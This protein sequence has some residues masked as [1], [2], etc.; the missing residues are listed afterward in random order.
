MIISDTD[1]QQALQQWFELDIQPNL[2]KWSAYKTPPIKLLARSLAQ[3]GLVCQ[4]WPAPLGDGNIRKQLYLHYFLAKRGLGSIGLG[5]ASHIDIG[6]RG[7]FEYGSDSLKSRWLKPALSGEAILSLAMTEPD[8]GS[9]LQGI[10]FKADKTDT[11]WRLNGT[12]KGITN[13]P[14]ADLCIVLVRTHERRSPFSYSLFLLPMDTPGVERGVALD[15]LG[16]NGCLGQMTV[17][18]AVIPEDY[19]LGAPGSGLI[20]LMKHL[21]SERLIVSSRMLGLAQHIYQQVE[22]TLALNQGSAA[23]EF[24]QRLYAIYPKLLAFH[25]FFDQCTDSYLQGDLNDKDSAMLKYLGSDILDS[26]ACTLVDLY[27]VT[28]K[29][30]MK[31]AWMSQYEAMGLALAGGSKEIMLSL[32]GNTL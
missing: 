7:L 29:I 11:G 19:L 23:A 6:C 4:G 25:A 24:Q 30:D 31:P 21:Q 13:L 26:L 22:H 17:T 14:F 27:S 10:Q 20:T 32:I 3:R 18:D 15:T 28:N 8:A 5:L 16:F 9:D 2:N 12:K 1:Y